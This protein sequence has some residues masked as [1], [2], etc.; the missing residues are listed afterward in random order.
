MCIWYSNLLQSPWPGLALR[1]RY[2]KLEF[3]NLLYVNT[4]CACRRAAPPGWLLGFALVILRVYSKDISNDPRLCLFRSVFDRWRKKLNPMAERK[5]FSRFAS[6]WSVRAIRP[7]RASPLS[8]PHISLTYYLSP[9]SLLFSPLDP[10]SRRQWGAVAAAR[11]DKEMWRCRHRRWAVGRAP[12]C[13]PERPPRGSEEPPRRELHTGGAI[14]G[15]LLHVCIY[16]VAA[17]PVLHGYGGSAACEG[18]HRSSPRAIA[19]I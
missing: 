4:R 12:P 2:D 14:V 16:L 9:L 15:A 5:L 1:T 19:L 6:T 3:S 13:G 17:G 7:V 18:V 11:G 8:G 10:D